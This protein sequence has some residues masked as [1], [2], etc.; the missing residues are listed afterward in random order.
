MAIERKGEFVLIQKTSIR[1]SE[2]LSAKPESLVYVDNFGNIISRDFPKIIVMTNQGPQQFLYGIGEDEKRDDELRQ[3][4]QI[5]GSYQAQKSDG[6][7]STVINVSSSTGVNI[8]SNSKD[9]KISQQNINEAKGV[10]QEMKIE[11]EKLT[12]INQEL[13]E[14]ILAMILET[15]QQLNHTGEI[16]RH[17]FRSLLRITSDIASLSGLVLNLGQLLGFI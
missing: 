3:L 17:S 16:K 13:R 2:I 10:L 4:N 9:V 12:D 11:L 14:D 7:G 15:E 1:I 6:Q 5:I 8:V